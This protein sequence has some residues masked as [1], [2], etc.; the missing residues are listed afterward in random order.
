M[1]ENVMIG[2]LRAQN[3]IELASTN[4]R[5]A[6]SLIGD[7][8]VRVREAA[9]VRDEEGLKEG[10]EMQAMGEAMKADTF[11]LLDNALE[12]LNV[13]SVSISADDY[14]ESE[15]LSENSQENMYVDYEHTEGESNAV[16]SSVVKGNAKANA[17]FPRLRKFD[18]TV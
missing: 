17:S 18:V 7:G 9:T 13:S 11:D 12:E 1:L 5:V 10:E 14:E 6:N 3:N 2:I 8:R 15:A 4:Q 16:A